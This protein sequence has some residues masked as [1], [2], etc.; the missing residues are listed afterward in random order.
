[1]HNLNLPAGTLE[2]GTSEYLVRT[3]GE[4][5]S[6]REIEK[7]I[8]RSRGKGTSLRLRDVAKVSDT[9]EKPRTLSRINGKPSIS[10]TIQKRKEGNTI[11]LVKQVR[12]LVEK[13]QDKA[14]E[15]VVLSAVNDYS[16][17]LKERL[18]VLQNNAIFG[19]VLVVLLLYIFMGWR[20]ALFAALG[21]PVSFMAT[22]AFLY[23][24]GHTLNGVALF[25]LILVVGIVVDDAI[26]VIENVFRH[27]QEGKSPRKAAIIGAEE[28]SAPV[29]SASLTTVAAFGPLMFMS[30]VAGQFMR[31]V[32]MVVI[33]VILASLFEVFTILPA[34]IAEWSKPSVEE[35]RRRK[36]FD[37]IRKR[38]VRILKRII[39]WR[40][41][42][43]AGVLGLGL[44][45]CVG[46]FVFLDKEFFPSEDFSQFYIR[47]EMPTA[48]SLKETTAV[49]TKVEEIALSL[50]V[51][52]RA[53]VV[54]NI[55]SITP[56]SNLEGAIFRSNVGEVLVELV[57][58]DQ[59]KRSVDEV[60]GE[61][62]PKI[63]G[64]SGIEK[65]TFKKLQG[66]P[67]QGKDVEVK[68]KGKRF[69]QLQE[70]TELLKGELG[71]MDGVYDIQD[72]FQPGKSELRIR[73]KEEK[74]HQYGLNIFQIAHN[75]RN[76]LEGNVTTTYR[77]AD[78]AIDVM[79]KY[80]PKDLEDLLIPIP[81]GAIVPLKDVAE[82]RREE[83]YAEIRRFDGERAITV[84]ASVDR[85]K[86]SPF[87]ANQALIRA[88]EDMESAFPGYRLDFRGVF[89]QTQES[90]AEL[91]KLFIISIRLLY[92]I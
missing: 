48:Y 19:L 72:D 36:W 27:M 87:K 13:W 29:L 52:E 45:L 57:P 17:I 41:A 1:A 70:I 35:Q 59:R 56:T 30:G 15:G 89:D 16:V 51:E 9:Y 28:V 60:I 65:F 88:F 31:V 81:T 6:L 77:D 75:V 12:D 46:A 47:L 86:T 82:V 83:G 69:T 71:Q 76:A 33:L 74:A 90:F 53:A 79:V 92:A 25:G 91:W 3:M 14:P 80:D 38:Y 78:E 39:R 61:I 50:P 2:E 62:R 84:S 7:T 85:S 64:I 63:A 42:V 49:L 18:G 66:G 8:I 21:I 40:Y 73:V 20:N 43:V 4:F 37:I 26:V 68:I 67:S 11:K 58:S 24:S 23:L 54:S 55:G 5:R 34:H 44:L 32:P 10:L 22:F